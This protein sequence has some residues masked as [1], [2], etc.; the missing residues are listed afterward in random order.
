VTLP[1]DRCPKI[2]R[3]RSWFEPKPVILPAADGFETACPALSPRERTSQRAAAGCSLFPMGFT[4]ANAARLNYMQYYHN[5]YALNQYLASRGY[6]V[7]SVN[8]RSG[9][10]YGMEFREALN[11]GATGASEFNDVQ[12]AG[13]YLRSRPDVDPPASACGA[14]PTGV[15]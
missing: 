7:L 12:G 1:R 8:Y 13:L 5:A 14:A 3:P 2:F 15:T 4:P 9:I 11:Y 10:G 6:I